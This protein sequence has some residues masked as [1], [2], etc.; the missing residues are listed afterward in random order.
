MCCAAFKRAL[1]L[2][3]RGDAGRPEGMVPDP[4]LNVS[5]ARPPLDHAVGV[6]LPHGLA[7]ERAGLADPRPEQRRVRISRDAAGG[8]DVFIEVPLQIV[9]TRN[10][11][12]L[13]T[14]FVQADPS[15]ASL[16]EI[17]THFHLEHGVDAGEGVDRSRYFRSPQAEDWGR[18]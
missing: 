6:L 3:V 16:H 1:V 5:A 14:F 10:L 7:G 17:V 11:M 8:G 2:Q 9:V 12:I 15:S 18:S 4:H 13:T